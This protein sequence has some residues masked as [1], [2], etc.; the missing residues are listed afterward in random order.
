MQRKER[1]KEKAEKTKERR[2][3]KCPLGGK[4]VEPKENKNKRRGAA[5]YAL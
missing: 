2:G 4:Y 5:Y 3:V 1:E